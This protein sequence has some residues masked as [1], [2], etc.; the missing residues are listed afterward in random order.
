ML[1]M[2]FKESFAVTAAFDVD[3]SVFSIVIMRFIRI[4]L[5]YLLF[6]AQ[7]EAVK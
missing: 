7:C 6:V 5:I 3:E 2:L 4:E 1:S